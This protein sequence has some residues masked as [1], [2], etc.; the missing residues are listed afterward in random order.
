MDDL[1]RSLRRFAT[2]RDWDKYHSPKN[3]SMAL[4]K[5]TAEIVE[6]FQWL[7]QE[8]SRNLSVEKRARLTEEI[9]DVL[10]YLAVLADKFEIDPVEAAKEKLKKNIEKY[11]ADKV[12]GKSDKYTEYS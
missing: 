3:L 8:E 6:L 12:K 7:T 4:S 5:E 2:E 10:I 9:G 1:V 11:P